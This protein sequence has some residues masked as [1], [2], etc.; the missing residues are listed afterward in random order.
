LRATL[1][2]LAGGMWPAGRT[3]PRPAL[4]SSVSLVKQLSRRYFKILKN[5]NFQDYYLK[6]N[7]SIKKLNKDL[8]IKQS[9]N[10]VTINKED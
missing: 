6:K 3:L 4:E 10:K 1:R 9:N 8:F 2:S 5:D 7:C